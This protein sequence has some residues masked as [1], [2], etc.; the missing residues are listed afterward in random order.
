MKSE[1]SNGKKKS[2]AFSSEWFPG[3]NSSFHIYLASI[4]DEAES[5]T[6]NA[7]QSDGFLSIFSHK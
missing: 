6:L 7:A 3:N 5:E 2:T 1:N 4:Q